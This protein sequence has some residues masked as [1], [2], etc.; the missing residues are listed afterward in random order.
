MTISA[1]AE[2]HKTKKE[3]VLGWIEKGYIP[4]ANLEKDFIPDSA[5]KPYT[6]ARAQAKN[7]DSIYY[8]I[9]NAT[10]NLFHVMPALYG[11]CEDE[12]NGYIDR[13]VEAGCLVKR[14]TDGVTYYD[15]TFQAKYY[16][17]SELLK[18]LAPAIKAASEGATAAAL[19]FA[20]KELL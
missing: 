3:T 2:K 14:I 16:K 8:S 4:G 18:A 15:A 10:R 17:K 1:F 11:L 6:R 12:F 7:S 13:L 19:K 9:V 20:K 5:K